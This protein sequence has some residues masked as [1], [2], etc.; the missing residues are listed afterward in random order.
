MPA[1]EKPKTKAQ[2]PFPRHFFTKRVKHLQQIQENTLET[3][4]SEHQQ[5]VDCMTAICHLLLK[6]LNTSENRQ[7]IQIWENK[8]SEALY[9]T[10]YVV[11]TEQPL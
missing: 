10:N 4:L 9:I 2:D 5:L 11:L 8:T 6:C 7:K 1:T 3:D